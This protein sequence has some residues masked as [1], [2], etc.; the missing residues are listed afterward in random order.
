MSKAQRLLIALSLL[1]VSSAG[2]QQKPYVPEELQPWQDWVLQDFG[3]RECPFFFD[4]ALSTQQ[5][6]LCTWPG[7]LNLDIA[8]QSATFSQ[9]WTVTAEGDWIP[10]PG[11]ETYWPENVTVDGRAAAVV[12]RNGVP[13]V[14]LQPGTYTLAGRI[15]WDAR[16]RQLPISA[17]IGSLQ[18]KVDGK[19][20]AFP[21][22]TP[23]AVWI[24]DA[25]AA[26][27]AQNEL[28][29]EVYRLIEDSIPA[30]LT[31]VMQI[32]VA[33]EVREETLGPVLPR[34]FVPVAMRS[35]LPAMLNAE[36]QL[37]LQL[38][39]G[40]WDIE[41]GA[42][43][44][45]VFE[46]LTFAPPGQL[47]PATEVWS[48]KSN[49]SLRIA[50]PSGPEPLDPMQTGVPEDWLEMPT[51]YLA[52]GQMLQVSER[53]RGDI[54]TNNRLTL[55]RRLWLDFSGDGFSFID[56]I[57][58]T[59]RSGWRLDMQAPYELL[60][61]REFD[62]DLLV[63][64]GGEPGKTGIE[65]RDA[66]PEIQALG[67]VG[68]R[69]A[70]A[71][72]GW[73]ERF[74]R[75]GVQLEL[76]PGHL[77]VAAFGADSA[78]GAWLNRWQ[79]L[80]FFL[81][82]IVTI[83]AHRLFGWRVAAL[84]FATLF[85]SL[86]EPGAP[87]WAW[88]NL[89]AAIALLRVVPES[90]FRKSLNTYRLASLALIVVLAIPFLVEQIRIGLYPQ[91]EDTVFA[92][93]P[94]S[95]APVALMD[96]EPGRQEM[97]TLEALS[98]GPEVAEDK[99][100]EIVVFAQKTA[101]EIPRYAPDALL[102]TGPGKPEWGWKSYRLQ[103]AGPVDAER[104][105]NLV[106]ILPWLVSLLRFFVV[107]LVLGLI[108]R[109][110]IDFTGRKFT[111]PPAGPGK[112]VASIWPLLFL[113]ACLTATPSNSEAEVP[114]REILN[115]LRARLLQPPQC[116]PRCA[117]IAKASV[118]VSEDSLRMELEASALETVALALPGSES[119]W[120]P[121][122]VTIDGQ[123]APAIYR[124][125]SRRLWILLRKG[126]RRIELSGPLPQVD[127]LELPFPVPPRIINAQARGWTL[128]GISE[129]RLVSGSLALI[130][131]TAQS[132]AD[133]PAQWQSDRFPMFVRVE[134]TLAIG[135]DWEVRTSI[136][137][138]APKEGAFSLEIPLLPDESVTTD[139]LEVRNGKVRV[140]FGENDY[141]Q[142]WDASL[143]RRS[144]ILLQAPD[145]NTP[146]TETWIVRV[147]DEWHADFAGL[148]NSVIEDYKAGY[149]TQFDPRPGEALSIDVSRPQAIAGRTLAVDDVHMVTDIGAHSRNVSLSLAYRSTQG[150]QHAIALP[151]GAEVEAVEIDGRP[152][153]LRAIDG[154]LSL[155]ILPG[156]HHINVRWRQADP[157]GWRVH[158][159]DVNL[160]AAA[161]NI[162][163]STQLPPNR[164]I[165]G[166]QG[167]SLGP[168]V[169]Y[170]PELAALVLLAVI[171]GRIQLTPLATWQWVL[172]G[173]GFSTF[174]WSALFIV[175]AWLL[176]LG[177]RGRW[178]GTD[179]ATNFN[180]VQVGIG[181]LSLAALLSFISS[182]PLGLLGSPDMHITG[183]GSSGSMLQ[184]FADRSETV[185]PQASVFSLPLWV[186]KALILAW[187]LWVSLA[188]VKWLPWGWQCLSSGALWKAQTRLPLAAKNKDD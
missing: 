181:L 5:D 141:A 154:A 89:L 23:A 29:V 146:W 13:S 59:M 160:N 93:M 2:A 62:E 21:Q 152:E 98:R 173:L 88:L 125:E 87:R 16:P 60:N 169:L 171:L 39:P 115:E 113:A 35:E 99:F 105:L 172:L 128:D 170:W 69:D 4:R 52:P 77:L 155:P 26:E 145:A 116:A 176:A 30:T 143:P 187:A 179:N 101:E 97:R 109:M 32:T 7:R 126:Q 9:R 85:L 79:L 96:M 185:L 55:E 76:P 132:D 182:L 64:A 50:I 148:P 184:W 111:W 119:G 42:R 75:V 12:S 174:S 130:R 34:G 33:G 107:A 159:P 71:V 106:I 61:A 70:V 84:A 3:Y 11:D 86:H 151:D 168:A 129:R 41:I 49:D 8:A 38:R 56:S 177:W 144:P 81:L 178:Q 83:A 73:N 135:L 45:G 6:F 161:S 124:D 175:V 63:T 117:E 150:G 80:D 48:F 110:V 100:E 57:G 114:P 165:L 139:G 162:R 142:G 147:A 167:P 53:S 138:I 156:D 92:A 183:N 90:K 46:Q 153:P 78:P 54:A 25:P 121:A 72:T 186:Y 27:R 122:V 58:G 149:F 102:Q 37:R 51:F 134:R 188:L 15:G 74:D 14:Y 43:A 180:L 120:R 112:Q 118:V 1:I 19:T 164:W 137:R 10:L 44:S 123:A 31:T 131:Q 127:T 108:G 68:T 91:L 22:R 95:A 20:I 18:L 166:T 133:A 94:R 82:L 103:W 28:T 136:V 140:D 158:T 104:S 47:M 24:S 40:L 66:N 17:A 67:R 163:M 36:G 65:V 157:V